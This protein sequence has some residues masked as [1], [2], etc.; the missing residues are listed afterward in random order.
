MILVALGCVDY[1]PTPLEETDSSIPEAPD[2]LPC[3]GLDDDDDGLVDDGFRDTDRDGKA[4][5]QQCSVGAA[6]DAAIEADPYHCGWAPRDSR[7]WEA[8]S[9][10]AMPGDG[11]CGQ[12]IVVATAAGSVVYGE[13][14]VITSEYGLTRWSDPPVGTARDLTNHGMSVVRTPDGLRIAAL[15]D[16]GTL[17]LFDEDLDLVWESADVAR[18]DTIGYSWPWA[19]VPFRASDGGIRFAVGS[20]VFS[21]PD[22]SFASTRFVAGASIMAPSVVDL[23]LD[24]DPE[25]VDGCRVF[26]EDGDVLWQLDVDREDGKCE[27]ALVQADDDPYGEIVWY[28]PVIGLGLYD[29][30]GALLRDFPGVTGVLNAP[31]AADFDGDGRMDVATTH[32]DGLSAWK[33]SGELLWTQPLDNGRAGSLNNCSV[34]D[35]D[36]DGASE[37]IVADR[38][39][40]RVFDGAS[41]ATRISLP[42]EDG[43]HDHS[44][45]IADIDGDG[46][47]DLL[48]ARA[49]TDFSPAMEVYSNPSRAWPPAAPFWPWST[50]SGAG[51]WSDGT[52][53]DEP[54]TPWLDPGIFRGSPAVFVEGA[55]LSVEIVDSCV[56][57][58]DLP[59]SDVRLSVRVTNSGPQDAPVGVPVAV[60]VGDGA[61]G[62]VAREVRRLDA[63]I[64]VGTASATIELAL[65]RDAAAH[66]VRVVVGEDEWDERDCDAED[67]VAEWQLP[68]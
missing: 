50:W 34:F 7:V 54:P 60:L 17:G 39:S 4:D 38:S 21:Y 61:G 18:Y 41:G 35:F 20:G 42:H 33:L 10:S 13:C 63:P 62:W 52:L 46:S 56:A 23:D 48:V 26:D 14:S 37:V 68:D 58:A 66:G 36:G 27:H 57:D 3:N 6:N 31:C 67:H 8:N 44:V 55:D 2:E 40:V 43:V 32:A 24:G 19:P 45:W 25:I 47:A 11:R 30:N 5:C 9:L 65:D 28:Q 51:A 53:W 12:P 1:Q 29:T 49:A 22:G 64:P 15:T 59:D 16:D